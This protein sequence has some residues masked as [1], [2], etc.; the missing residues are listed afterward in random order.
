MDPRVLV[1]K[2]NIVHM[3][4]HARLERRQNLQYQVVAIATEP[5]A[6]GTIVEQDVARLKLEKYVSG[7]RLGGGVSQASA[8][9]GIR[10]N[11][12][13]PGRWIEFYAHKIMPPRSSLAS[14]AFKRT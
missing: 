12:T 3:Q 14:K 6:M 1:G 9:R 4:E 5:H 8:W 7:N 10:E 2:M 13:Q 11:L